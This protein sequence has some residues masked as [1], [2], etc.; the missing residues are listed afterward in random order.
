MKLSRRGLFL[1]SLGTAFAPV[2]KPR[3]LPEKDFG[4]WNRIFPEDYAS[5]FGMADCYQGFYVPSMGS[6][7]GL[8]SFE[9]DAE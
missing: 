7:F 9:R 8:A 1:A 5:L 4:P 3:A 2:W 6:V